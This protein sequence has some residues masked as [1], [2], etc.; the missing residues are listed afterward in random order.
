MITDWHDLRTGNMTLD[1]FRLLSDVNAKDEV[2]KLIQ[3]IVEAAAHIPVVAISYDLTG[4][5]TPE[6]IAE[7]CAGQW[8][9]DIYC[10]PR[11]YETQNKV[12]GGADHR[13]ERGKTGQNRQSGQAG[14]SAEACAEG[15]R[16]PRDAA[17]NSGGSHKRPE[18][19]RT[20][21]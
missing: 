16:R 7:I 4:A 17:G 8:S 3:D 15:A 2:E 10:F 11:T 12:R 18:P 21:G 5:P 20:R 1:E 6:D 14:Q 13:K 19:I 9:E